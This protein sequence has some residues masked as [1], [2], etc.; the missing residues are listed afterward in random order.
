[1]CLVCYRVMGVCGVLQGDGEQDGPTA[2]HQAKGQELQGD[3]CVSGVLQGDGEQDGPTAV[4]QAKGQ[5]WPAAVEWSGRG[6]GRD[7]GGHRQ[8]RLC[9]SGL[10]GRQSAA[11]LQ[12]GQRG[13]SDW[14]Q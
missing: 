8:H 10:C 6:V 7:G 9:G 11:T 1:M 5:E 4:H 13:G 14:L 2:V 12:P 3:R